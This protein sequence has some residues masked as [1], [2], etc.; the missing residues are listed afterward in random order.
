MS[1][2]ILKEKY[3]KLQSYLSSSKK[4]LKCGEL[5][6]VMDLRY[7]TKYGFSLKITFPSIGNYFYAEDF[8]FDR[9]SDEL[10]IT[11]YNG[12]ELIRNKINIVD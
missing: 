8:F 1:R 7:H 12:C 10:I 5:D 3:D 4:H 9:K 6:I 2:E 11:H